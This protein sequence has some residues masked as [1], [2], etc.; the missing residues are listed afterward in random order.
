MS[1]HFNHPN[2]SAA[3]NHQLSNNTRRTATMQVDFEYEIDKKNVKTQKIKLEPTNQMQQEMQ[4]ICQ[5]FEIKEPP[6]QFCLRT[7]NTKVDIPENILVKHAFVKYFFFVSS[8][9]KSLN[10]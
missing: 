3:I 6:E 1:S 2:P 8:F 9:L 10:M 5:A 4:T 7:K